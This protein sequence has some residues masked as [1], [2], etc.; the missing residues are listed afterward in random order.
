MGMPCPEA[1]P[2]GTSDR[3]GWRA[4][5]GAVRHRVAAER[6][7]LWCLVVGDRS[8]SLD[9]RWRR[10]Q[11]G[12]FFGSPTLGP[13]P[14]ERGIPSVDG[15]GGAPRDREQGTTRS[16]DKGAHAARSAPTP[17]V[18]PRCARSPARSTWTV[19]SCAR[20]TPW[21]PG[22]RGRSTAGTRCSSTWTCGLG[23]RS[24]ATGR[25]SCGYWRISERRRRRPG[26][27]LAT[28]WT[29]PGASREG[30]GGGRLRGALPLF[31]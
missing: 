9:I 12:R 7:I 3:L 17:A 11:R 24:A 27:G 30:E 31:L 14:A 10:Y 29:G 21:R 19:S 18:R 16:A 5:L 22:W 13:G 6:L 2:R 1:V 28:I 15:E 26:I 4:G 20:A 25:A 23:R 8:R